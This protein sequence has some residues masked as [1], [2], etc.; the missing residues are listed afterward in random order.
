MQDYR[1]KRI[2]LRLSPREREALDRL[3]A[4]K[5]TSRTRVVADLLLAAAPRERSASTL[6]ELDRTGQAAGGAVKV[7]A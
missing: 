4:L 6:V 5:Q 1:T 3:A 2:D 7:T